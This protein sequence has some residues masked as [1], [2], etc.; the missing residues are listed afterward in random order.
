MASSRWEVS[1]LTDVTGE[2]YPPLEGCMLQ[3][4]DASADQILWRTTF[5]G[6]QWGQLDDLSGHVSLLGLVLA[7]RSLISVSTLLV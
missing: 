6:T 3:F 1:S 5:W 4:W 2:R 7:G